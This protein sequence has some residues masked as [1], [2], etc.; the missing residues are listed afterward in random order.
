M[1]IFTVGS[2][3]ADYTTITTAYAAIPLD[4]SENKIILLEDINECV[5]FDKEIGSISSPLTIIGGAD[6]IIW[7]HDGFSNFDTISFG[8]SFGFMVFENISIKNSYQ[9]G[10]G[11]VQLLS[12]E[13]SVKISFIGC[14]ENTESVSVLL[15]LVTDFTL[16]SVDV[17]YCGETKS[18]EIVSNNNS[19]STNMYSPLVGF[20][21][22]VFWSGETEVENSDFIEF[23]S[24]GCL[25][26]TN[27]PFYVL[28]NDRLINLRNFL[29]QALDGSEY[30][31]FVGIFENFLNFC[32]YEHTI[33]KSQKNNVSI[34]KKIELISTLRDTDLIRYNTLNSYAKDIGY[35]I[36]YTRE[37]IENSNFLGLTEFENKSVVASKY[38]RNALREAPNWF[39]QKCTDKAIS[40]IL[41]SYGIVAEVSN[42]WTTDYV[43][44]WVTE[45]PSFELNKISPPGI[46]DGYYPTS[47][48]SVSINQ[49]LTF[50]NWEDYSEEL[51]D[52]INTIKPINTVFVGFSIFYDTGS[53]MRVLPYIRTDI[54]YIGMS[55]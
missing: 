51:G 1:A 44:D 50:G 23:Y 6:G 27:D 31:D 32:L 36:N 30:S 20:G 3:G 24:C 55:K 53:P 35:D 18:F 45:S 33:E 25:V 28:K 21:D 29:P 39:S 42:L 19:L 48:F 4:D 8:S 9:N 34:L 52:Y 5:L 11:A 15:E 40:T 14:S 54:D 17:L 16:D 46:I 7:D 22:G 2:S 13:D 41:F 10:F 47:H 43:K 12:E 49:R 38:I 26:E 37:I